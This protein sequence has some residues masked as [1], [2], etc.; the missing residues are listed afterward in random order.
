MS[1][2]IYVNKMIWH[3]FEPLW[4]VGLIKFTNRAHDAIMPLR[5]Q[6]G[7]AISFQRRNDV[8]FAPCVRWVL[9]GLHTFGPMV[10]ATAS[11]KTSTPLSISWRDSAPKR[12]SLAY[13]LWQAGANLAG[14]AR[15][16]ATAGRRRLGRRYMFAGKTICWNETMHGFQCTNF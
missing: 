9:F 16:R 8:I 4:E 11:A 3:H 14:R 10:T 5:H 2:Q 15:W 6:N 1:T 7:V 12:T 13:V